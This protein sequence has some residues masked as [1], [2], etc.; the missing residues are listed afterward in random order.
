MADKNPQHYYIFNKSAFNVKTLAVTDSIGQV[1]FMIKDKTKI[2]LENNTS[3]QNE[4]LTPSNNRLLEVKTNNIK[5]D[6]FYNYL[7]TLSKYKGAFSKPDEDKTIP[8]PSI[9][10]YKIKINI[11][12]TGTPDLKSTLELRV[13]D[14]VFLRDVDVLPQLPFAS[15]AFTNSE[16]DTIKNEIKADTSFLKDNLKYFDLDNNNIITIN[17]SGYRPCYSTRLIVKGAA[18]GTN[19]KPIRDYSLSTSVTVYSVD[20]QNW[21]SEAYANAAY[22]LIMPTD[23]SDSWKNLVWDNQ[24]MPDTVPQTDNPFLNPSPD[25]KTALYNTFNN[26]AKDV[27]T[28]GIIAT[29]DVLASPGSR[30]LYGEIRDYIYQ[31]DIDKVTFEIAFRL[32]FFMESLKDTPYKPY[33]KDGIVRD[34]NPYYTM[35]DDWF[36]YANELRTAVGLVNLNKTGISTSKPEDDISYYQLFGFPDSIKTIYSGL[37]SLPA[38]MGKTMHDENNLN[39]KKYALSHPL[40]H[41]PANYIINA[42]TKKSPNYLPTFKKFIINNSY[43]QDELIGLKTAGVFS[44]NIMNYLKNIPQNSFGYA[45]VT[46]GTYSNIY[47]EGNKTDLNLSDDTDYFIF[48][49]EGDIN[50]YYIYY[51][52]QWTDSTN[53]S[54]ITI[55]FGLDLGQQFWETFATY[56]QYNESFPD[57]TL[58]DNEKWKPILDQTII[59]ITETSS[60]PITKDNIVKEIM[61]K[62]GSQTNGGAKRRKNAVSYLLTFQDVLWNRLVADPNHF[63]KYKKSLMINNYLSE[64]LS[65]VIRHNYLKIH[66]E[67]SIEFYLDNGDQFMNQIEKL[68]FLTLCYNGGLNNFDPSKNAAK[69]FIHTLNIHDIRWMKYIISSFDKNGKHYL[70]NTYKDRRTLLIE[71]LNSLLIFNYYKQ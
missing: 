2:Y 27:S 40:P 36:G 65:Y 70:L 50:I 26:D 5:C 14:P 16:A 6:L 25:L 57:V 69:Y 46:N 54:S 39:F 7:V 24:I 37:N 71:L 45:K 62:V 58:A 29:A 48:K 11:S 61:V 3:T 42:G 10:I 55:G 32:P 13:K 67:G 66:T 22:P 28:P 35:F 38:Y 19:G 1:V 31:G 30:L 9:N 20:G 47:S 49:K 68:L 53:N 17:N 43:K 51:N 8:E 52:F 12:T 59:Q 18:K 41:V 60:T 63:L 4:N 23:R 33:T 44:L 21:F 34:N 64:A 15:I 56:T